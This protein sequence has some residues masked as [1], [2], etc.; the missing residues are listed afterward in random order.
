M[1]PADSYAAEAVA[2]GNRNAEPLTF[3][4]PLETM[5]RFGF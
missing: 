4:L 3:R 2:S 1:E 5:A